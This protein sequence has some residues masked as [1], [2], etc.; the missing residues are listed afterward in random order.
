MS[1]KLLDFLPETVSV[2]MG[3]VDK[4]SRRRWLLM[5]QE[6]DRDHDDSRFSRVKFT[7]VFAGP[8]I[9]QSHFLGKITRKLVIFVGLKRGLS[10]SVQTL[11]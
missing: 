5:E 1:I 2:S 6:K 4:R 9:F 8:R 3:Q 10:F 7:T 11:I